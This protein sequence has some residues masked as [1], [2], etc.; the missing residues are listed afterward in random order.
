MDTLASFKGSTALITGASSG[1][2]AGFAR[3]LAACGID[4]VITARSEQSL[5]DLADELKALYDI[6][7]D[8]VVLDLAQTDAPQKLFDHLQQHNKS[9]DI[10]INNAGFGKW[11]KFLHQPLDSYRDMLNL[12]IQALVDLTYLFLPAM[13]TQ[14]KG[15][16]IN[17]ASTAAFQPLP[18]IAVY[19]ASKSFVL[20]FS[21]A[22]AG[23]YAGQGIK[24]LA[25]CPGNTATNFAQTANADTTGM[26]VST[27]EDV[28]RAAI[29][30][31]DQNK[32]YCVPGKSN[33][34]TAQLS[35]ILP[36]SAMIK[37][38]SNMLKKRVTA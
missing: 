27:V 25:L 34:F 13:L 1:I 12:N 29:R 3:V 30:A 33:Y 7:I 37:M 14:N 4:L 17:L 15:I 23:E 10:L 21:E 19:G 11:A 8:V 28:V 20:N 6:E 26:V 22:L 24:F 35:R 5:Q 38:V 31:L 2:G 18:Y 16:V 36:R 32:L 9:I